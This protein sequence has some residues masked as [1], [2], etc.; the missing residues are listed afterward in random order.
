MRL[1]IPE[2]PTGVLEPILVRAYL[3]A[4]AALPLPD[5]GG[6][7]LGPHTGGALYLFASGVAE[8]VVK[9][10]IASLYPSLMMAY[11]IGPASDRL[12]ALRHHDILVTACDHIES[13]VE[14]AN[15]VRQ[16]T[17]GVDRRSMAGETRQS[18]TESFGIRRECFGSMST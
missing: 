13:D 6:A 18:G 1:I 15:A 7:E 10:D 12:G 16:A 8:R 17:Q 11:R 3:R 9:A 5:E 2:K 14:P 4:R